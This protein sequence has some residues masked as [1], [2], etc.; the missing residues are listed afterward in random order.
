MSLAGYQWKY[1]DPDPALVST[2]S[3]QTSF[4]EPIIKVLI[5]RG[6]SSSQ[7]IL[8]FLT[9]RLALLGSPFDMPDIDKAIERVIKAKERGERVAVYGDYDVD[10]ISATTLLIEMFAKV[11]INAG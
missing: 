1:K 4:S 8:E 2:L 7:D 5:N 9:P 3:K 11:G 10:G 6:F